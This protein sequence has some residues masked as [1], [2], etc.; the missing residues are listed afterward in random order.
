M[1]DY[2]KLPFDVHGLRH[3]GLVREHLHDGC[4][5]CSAGYMK[6]AKVHA[7]ARGGHSRLDEKNHYYQPYVRLHRAK[8]ARPPLAALQ[9]QTKTS[10]ASL[11]PAPWRTP[12]SE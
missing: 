7:G 10:S 6:I 12:D 9:A 2:S 8:L 1:D 5:Q 3:K 11:Q 4:A